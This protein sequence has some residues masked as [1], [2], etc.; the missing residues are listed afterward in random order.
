[1]PA[2]TVGRI[3]TRAA[4][5]RLQRSRARA[6]NGPVRANFVP[7]DQTVAGVFPQVGYA[8]GKGCGNAVVRNTLRRRLRESARA[9]APE[10]PRG[11]Y[12][13]RL[14]PAAA[15]TPQARLVECTQDVLRRA[16]QTAPVS[17]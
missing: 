11:R 1:M 4:F 7:V 3:Q 8:I 12:L 5:G 15:D 6:S 17:T 10:L 14:E 16:A 2:R 13:L 9:V